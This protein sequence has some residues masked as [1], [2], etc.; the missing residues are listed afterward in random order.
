M[1]ILLASEVEQLLPRLEMQCGVG[2]AT[3]NYRRPPTIFESSD[4]PATGSGIKL[5]L[6][7]RA[8]LARTVFFSFEAT[9]ACCNSCAL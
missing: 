9:G 1:R 8:P 5:G 2:V 7:F 4:R 3:E 6:S